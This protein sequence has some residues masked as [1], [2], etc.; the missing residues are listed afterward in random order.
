MESVR[1]TDL[2]LRRLAT[3]HE[4]ENWLM[5]AWGELWARVACQRSEG[6]TVEFYQGEGLG[7]IIIKKQDSENNKNT[8]N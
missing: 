3:R 5:E 4:S 8:H 6:R 1:Q 2:P 7:I